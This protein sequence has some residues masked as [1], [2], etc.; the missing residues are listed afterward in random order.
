MKNYDN[1]NEFIEGVKN[2]FPIVIGY[3]SVSFTFGI[4]AAKAG[5]SPGLATLISVT[6]LT[7]AGQ[8]AGL[9]LITAQASYIEVFLTQLIIN[10]RYGLMSLSLSQKLHPS[11]TT[12]K[13]LLIAFANTDEIFA[14]SVSRPKK[15]TTAY[16]VG[17]ELFPIVGWSLGTF[18]GAVTTSLLP[19]FVQSALGVALYGMF[20]AI[21]LP[22]ARSHKPVAFVA[23][24][25][26][27][28][29]VI[30][31]YAPG[32]QRIS[33][34]FVIIITTVLS[35]SLGALLWPIPDTKEGDS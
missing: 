34:G 18:A 10:L 32:L 9:T 25:A 29:S 16:M 19:P 8:F 11:V 7:S 24:M 31:T 1:K 4:M 3:F 27:V 15:V 2:S 20:I 12:G 35:A 13:R 14:V 30:F 6:N 17:L 21:V 28:L 23:L 26:A 22:P 33:A 5:L